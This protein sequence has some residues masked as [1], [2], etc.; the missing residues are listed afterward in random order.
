[1][2]KLSIISIAYNDL[3]GLKRTLASVQAQS[4]RE[5]EHIIIDGG[6]TD[7]TKEFLHQN[8]KSFSHAISEPDEGIYDAMNKGL[9]YANGDWALFLNGGDVL[10]NGSVLAE[11]F[12]D[13]DNLE[14]LYF[15]RAQIIV[16]ESIHWL[17]PPTFVRPTNC[18]HWLGN[19]LP[20]HQAM[21]FPKPFYEKNQYRLDL[22]ISADSDY[23][24]RAFA[25]G[26]WQF[27]DLV[28]CKFFLDG[29]SSNRSLKNQM[30][31]VRDRFRRYQGPKKY[32]DLF[33][34]VPKSLARWA[35][36]K[37]MQDRSHSLINRFKSSKDYVKL[38]I[39]SWTD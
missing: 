19:N 39:R 10:K 22:K 20:N 8:Q 16:S 1:M 24:E 32:L 11:C 27:L 36:Y 28:V 2:T 18:K 12:A 3:L 13:M 9:T 15:G 25:N 21:F 17:Y 23:K 6:S 26:S 35:L 30:T 4:F 37:M 5:F 38:I 31:H 14:A 7:G 29:L 34:S 33:F